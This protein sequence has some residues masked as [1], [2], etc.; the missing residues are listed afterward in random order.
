M[1]E[2]YEPKSDFLNSVIAKEA[3]LTGEPFGEANLRLLIEMTRDPDPSNRDW[4][5]F[6]LGQ[7]RVDTL[8][9]RDALLRVAREDEG[10]VQAEAV[11]ALAVRE[12]EL[13]LPFVQA[14]LQSES[15]WIPMFEA[16]ELCAHPSLIEDMRGWAEPSDDPFVDRIAASALKACELAASKS[17]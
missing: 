16:A 14:A 6:L 17:S 15:V 5:T 11:R 3:P 2:R 1:S 10:I 12:P 13:A 7:A 9:I 4:A 8:E